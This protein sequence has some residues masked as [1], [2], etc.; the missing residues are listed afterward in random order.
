MRTV[1]Y[2]QHPALDDMVQQ[3]FGDVF[4]NTKIQDKYPLTDIYEEDGIAYMD[5]AVAGFKK[6][7]IKITIDNSTLTI[8]GKKLSDKVPKNREYIKKDIAKRNFEKSYSL[9]FPVETVEANIKDGIL[10]IKIIPYTKREKNTKQI[11][12]K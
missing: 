8:K 2:P 9:V 11:E 12:I 4:G 7:E 10:T 5:I 1:L 3:F 6:D